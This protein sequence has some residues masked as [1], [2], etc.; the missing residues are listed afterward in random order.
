[1][2]D[3]EAFLAGVAKYLSA[4]SVAADTAISRVQEFVDNPLIA[5]ANPILL[6]VRSEALQAREKFENALRHLESLANG[7]VH[8]DRPEIA[9]A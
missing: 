3:N 4:G 7:G 5:Q 6:N 1:M 9:A 8:D 2:M